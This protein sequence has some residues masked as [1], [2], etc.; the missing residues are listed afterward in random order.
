M[1]QAFWKLVTVLNHC[2]R[3][4]KALL[5]PK[6]HTPATY[7]HFRRLLWHLNFTGKFKKMEVQVHAWL[8]MKS[9]PQHAINYSIN[10]CD[11]LATNTKEEITQ[12]SDTPAITATVS[13]PP[14]Y[15]IQ[16]IFVRVLTF[17]DQGITKSL[18]KLLACYHPNTICTSILK[19][20]KNHHIR[21]KLHEKFLNPFCSKADP[22]TE[23]S[24]FPL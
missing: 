15:A 10:I 7:T 12:A 2:K 17:S 5:M 4:D 6:I 24:E 22:L 13:P 20:I 21:Q 8:N 11:V 23:D 19:T 16:S 9:P 1:L 3:K 18:R 14:D